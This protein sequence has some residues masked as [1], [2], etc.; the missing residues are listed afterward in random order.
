MI[1]PVLTPSAFHH[2]DQYPG[3]AIPREAR[4]VLWAYGFRGFSPQSVSPWLLAHGKTETRRKGMEEASCWPQQSQEAEEKAE[5][6]EDRIYPAQTHVVCFLQCHQIVNW[7]RDQSTD[8]VDYFSKYPQMV[9]TLSVCEPV[10]ETSYLSHN[11]H[12]TH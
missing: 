12:N 5:G 6:T 10:E 7:S 4:L 2:C 9:I 1:G 11:M 3:G 8:W